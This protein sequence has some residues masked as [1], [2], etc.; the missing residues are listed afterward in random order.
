[1]RSD[2]VLRDVYKRQDRLLFSA[3]D[4]RD[5]S[6]SNVFVSLSELLGDT[7]LRL[8]YSLFNIRCV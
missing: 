7:D 6:N 4:Y 3:E 2:I 1:M 8:L 5:L